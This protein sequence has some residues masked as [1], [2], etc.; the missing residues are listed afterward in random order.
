M[1]IRKLTDWQEWLDADRLLATAFLDP[2][3]EG[4]EGKARERRIAEG[5]GRHT[6]PEETWGC[7][8]EAGSM[9]SAIITHRLSAAFD[10][11]FVPMGELDMVGS[12]PEHRANG[13]VRAMV[14]QVLGEFRGR[15]DLFALLVP[16]SFAFY[17]KFGFEACARNLEVR[18]PIAQLAPFELTCSVRQVSAATDVEILRGLYERF[19]I[20]KNLVI[21]RS[22]EAWEWRGNGEFG[23][24]DWMSKDRQRYTYLF[25][26]AGATAGANAVHAH[27]YLTF[28]FEAGE[29]GPFIGTMRV[30]ELV[31]DSPRVLRDILGFIYGMRAKLADVV[32]HPKGG[33]DLALLV[34][35]PSE[36]ETRVEGHL[37]ARV[38]DVRRVLEAMRYPCEA[39]RFSLVVE[40]DFM[41]ENAGCYDVTFAGGVAQSV[42]RVDS[43]A[44][45]VPADL[46]VDETTLTQLVLGLVDLRGAE[47]RPTTVVN[48]NRGTLE[49]VFV[50]KA[51]WAG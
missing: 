49:R 28:Y 43:A 6:R 17:R 19:A 37:I 20:D 18:L 15:G 35:E 50:R 31:Y 39:G 26:D 42:E 1:Q 32:I 10:G 23:Q 21:R 25:E 22:D 7:F 33:E 4:T 3:D 14:R 40:D 16:F 5:E 30:E 11:S 48:A 27:G 24:R 2:W 29:A 12:L 9:C 47:L 41:P 45:S 38:L 46:V 13:S 36:V 34:P 51:V 8:D 44:S